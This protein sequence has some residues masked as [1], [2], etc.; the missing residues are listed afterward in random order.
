MF[1]YIPLKVTSQEPQL[2]PMVSI[3]LKTILLWVCLSISLRVKATE[4]EDVSSFSLEDLISTA[5]AEAEAETS[6]GAVSTLRRRR[7]TE[8]D[9]EYN[10]RLKSHL[11]MFE[12]VKEVEVLG[13]SS[14]PKPTDMVK[15]TREAKDV[16]P[17]MKP[18]HGTHR[19]EQD[20]VF[21][22]AA[23]YG[24]NNYVCFVESLRAT[25]FT[26]DIVL[27]VSELDVKNTRVWE[28]LK[29]VP[30]M[31]V[32]A[33]KLVCYNF[34]NEIVASAKGG[35]R[36]CRCQELYGIEKDGT[37]EPVEDPRSQRVIATTRYEI[38]WIMA[39]NYHPHSWILLV[40]ARDTYFQTNPFANVPRKTDPTAKSGLL[41]FFG[42]NIE[43]TRI[44]KSKSNSKWIL[45]AYGE[46]VADA[47]KDKPT[48]CSG[49]TMG[50]Q[51]AL[52]TY[53]RAIVAESDDT[54]TVLMGA[55]Q[56]FHNFLYYSRKLINADRIH[57]I[58]VFD[59]GTGTC[60]LRKDSMRCGVMSCRSSSKTCIADS[61][62][63]CSL[64]YTIVTGIVN[65][66]G[67][68]RTSP[69]KD[70]GNGKI[71][72]S[73]PGSDGKPE[74]EVLNWD[75]TKAAVVHQFDRHKELSEYFFKV[76]TGEL[77]KKWRE[78]HSR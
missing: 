44:G 74:Y 61:F 69:L 71:T 73:S 7:L 46:K 57:D 55:D 35:M 11:S 2:G 54:G 48:I 56:G 33:P 77:L 63:I 20:A 26:G 76:K 65:N 27:S 31:V 29:S 68:L 49:A 5:E 50:E 22:Y 72:R 1:A 24:L 51:V 17:Y 66:M 13:P 42:E 30:G 37:L 39:Q 19:P 36:T 4:L 60:V 52:D 67:A 34:E 15:T 78:E 59:Q 28:Y 10:K 43:A 40:D 25:G 12:P 14:F 3:L 8:T 41:Y 9:Q 70:W 38:Y 45:N 75:G 18:I 6:T 23:E 53:A 47:L 32:Y 58:V 62:Y 21:A 16:K 64:I